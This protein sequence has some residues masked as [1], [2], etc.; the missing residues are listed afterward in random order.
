MPQ[1]L[2]ECLPLVPASV[3]VLSLPKYVLLNQAFATQFSHLTNLTELRL[4]DCEIH[5]I[6]V[7]EQLFGYLNNLIKLELVHFSVLV[8]N[9]DVADAA[10]AV[11]ST[12]TNLKSLL[13]SCRSE[14]SE[15]GMKS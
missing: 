15:L 14:L 9:Y 4:N 1:S 10:A 13:L 6:E 7:L 8:F 11:L 12:M 2:Q 5:S 3:K